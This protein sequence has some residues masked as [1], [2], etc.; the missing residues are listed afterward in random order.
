MHLRIVKES[1]V[2]FLIKKKFRRHYEKF[3]IFGQG[4]RM[5]NVTTQVPYLF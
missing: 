1:D 4:K 2:I 5:L 3:P